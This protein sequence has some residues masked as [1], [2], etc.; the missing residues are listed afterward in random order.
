MVGNSCGLNSLSLLVLECDNIVCAG[1]F[2]KLITSDRSQNLVLVV[3]EPTRLLSP[4]QLA[5][6]LSIIVSEQ[7]CVSNVCSDEVEF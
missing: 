5:W 6:T 1:D 3:E 7:A 2:N 4:A